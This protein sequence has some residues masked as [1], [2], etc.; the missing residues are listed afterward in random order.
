MP[1]A[2]KLHFVLAEVESWHDRFASSHMRGSPLLRAFIALLILLSLAFP[3]RHFLQ[4]DPAEASAAA[5]AP[6]KEAAAQTVHLQ[7]NF[8]TPPA[9][10]SVLSLGNEVWA[11]SAPAAEVERDLS[12]VFPK[13][14]VDLQF[15]LAW[16]EGTHAAAKVRLTSPDG[17]D[18]TKYVW[19]EGPASEVLSFP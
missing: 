15:D 6:A 9:H 7:I 10:F 4:A 14:G 11:E 5:P 13:E 12:L 8:T 2:R 17:T 3:L 16:P 18:Y 1:Y 19:G